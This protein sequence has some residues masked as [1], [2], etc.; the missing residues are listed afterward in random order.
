M[1]KAKSGPV[2]SYI[3]NIKQLPLPLKK[4]AEESQRTDYETQSK[5]TPEKPEDICNILLPKGENGDQRKDPEHLAGAKAREDTGSAEKTVDEEHF[6]R[7][8]LKQ[9]NKSDRQ[10][11]DKLDD[12][13]DGLIEWKNAGKKPALFY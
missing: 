8:I 11:V 7:K 13:F 6:Y 5:A 10:D 2:S 9:E 1:G 3:V 4:I 12:F